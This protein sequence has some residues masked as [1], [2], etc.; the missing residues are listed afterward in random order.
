[1][2]LIVIGLGLLASQKI[3]VPKLVNR[4]LENDGLNSSAYVAT[5]TASQTSAATTSPKLPPTPT[6]KPIPRPVVK[7][8]VD[9][10]VTI[11]PTCPVERVP[12]D[13]QCADKPYETTLILASTIIGRNGG[14]LIHTDAEGRFSDDLVPGIYTI[15]AQDGAVMP[16]LTPVTFQIKSNERLHLD[17]KFDSGIR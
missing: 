2:I 13:P 8:G 9:G 15:R 3:W 4:I 5:S 6:P 12:A 1:M 11:G 16:R 14:V 7:G 10:V 17:L